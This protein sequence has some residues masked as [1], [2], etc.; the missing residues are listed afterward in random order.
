MRKEIVYALLAC[1]ALVAVYNSAQDKQQDAFEAWKAEYGV[2]WAPHEESYRRTI[3]HKNLAKIELHNA[4]ATQTYKM[5][6]NQFTP[7]T[8][9]EFVQTYLSVMPELEVPH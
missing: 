4:D 1:I 9:E 6:V 8:T 3:F 5:G 2:N 7:F